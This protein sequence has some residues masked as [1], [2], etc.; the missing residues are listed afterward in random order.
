MHP[1]FVRREFQQVTSANAYPGLGYSN[2][3]YM[4]TVVVDLTKTKEADLTLF[5]V[6]EQEAH[7][8]REDSPAGRAGGKGPGRRLDTFAEFDRLGISPASRRR[9]LP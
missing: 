3:L 9:P 8:V 7:L 2:I 6:E 1:Q 5:L 4:A